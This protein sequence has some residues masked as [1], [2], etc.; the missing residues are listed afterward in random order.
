VRDSPGSA[1]T[2]AEM[3]E[4]ASMIGPGEM[5]QGESIGLGATEYYEPPSSSYAIATHVA[6]VAA[7]AATGLLTLERYY[8]VHDC[9]SKDGQP[10][11]TT[12]LDYTV[13]TTPSAVLAMMGI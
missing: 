10:M 6:Q 3:A 2:I 1:V 8:A 4:T 5:P 13:P 9:Y 11:A 12:L 7:D